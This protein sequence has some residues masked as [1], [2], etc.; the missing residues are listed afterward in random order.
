MQVPDGSVTVFA[1]GISAAATV[2]A[3]YEPRT[4]EP[5]NALCVSERLLVYVP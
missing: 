1:E 3:M 2:K 5:K 4:L